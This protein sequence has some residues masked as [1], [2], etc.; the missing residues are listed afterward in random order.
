VQFNGAAVGALFAVEVIHSDAAVRCGDLQACLT[1]RE[2]QSRPWFGAKQKCFPSCNAQ[3]ATAQAKK[4]RCAPCGLVYR[5]RLT[6]RVP[7]AM[8]RAKSRTQSRSRYGN[9]EIFGA[10]DDLSPPAALL[11]DSGWSGTLRHA[12]DPPPASISCFSPIDGRGE[13]LR[14]DLCRAGADSLD[15][16]G[17][18]LVDKPASWRGLSRLSPRGASAP[19]ITS[20]P[21]AHHIRP[22]RVAYALSSYTRARLAGEPLALEPAK[23]ARQLEP[24]ESVRAH[25]GFRI[26]AA[27]QWTGPSISDHQIRWLDSEVPPRRMADLASVLWKFFSRGRYYLVQR[28]LPA[29][30]KGL[31]QS[32]WD[33]R[34]RNQASL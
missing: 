18:D 19:F 15:D 3:N 22:A 25:A 9:G 33:G 7:A 8:E 24:G 28:L 20:N 10:S 4:S 32:I 1:P 12:L 30:D 31:F 2:G 21:L 26:H 29:R 6:S 11:A 17:L 14:D 34:H 23:G 5:C 16:V 13:G 27:P